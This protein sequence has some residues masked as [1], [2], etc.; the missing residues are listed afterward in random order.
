MEYTAELEL[1]QE[2]IEYPDSDGEPMA[3]SDF[4]RKPLTYA[5][6]ALD[7]YFRD[8]SD[9]YVSGNMLLYYHKGNRR[10]VVAPDVFVVIGV[11]KRLRR[12]Y[13]LWQEEKAPNFV[14]EITSESTA[15]IDQGAKKGLYARLGVQEYFQYDPTSD[16]LAPALQG[17]TLVDDHYLPLPGQTL[18]DGTLQIYSPKLA[19]A[20]QLTSDGVFHFMDL[21][22]GHVLH[23]YAEEVTAR[24]AAEVRA[25]TAEAQV[26]EEVTARQALEARLA[27]LEAHLRSLTEK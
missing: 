20:L 2:E 10:A 17:L 16:Y 25:A 7:I 9:V 21:S 12:S 26:K 1:L 8:R 6:E 13:L 23:T 15:H 14:L 18:A 19:L 5:V 4:Q 22:T 11:E 3:E 27:E 24:Q